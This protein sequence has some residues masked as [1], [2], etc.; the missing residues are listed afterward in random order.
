MLGLLMAHETQYMPNTYR[1][2]ITLYANNLFCTTA[3]TP[4]YL[5]YGGAKGKAMVL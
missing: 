1:I 2:F 5:A 3:T 4:Q